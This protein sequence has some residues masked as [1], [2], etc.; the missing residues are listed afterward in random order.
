M[1]SAVTTASNVLMPAPRTSGNAMPLFPS[2]E[3]IARAVVG[4]SRACIWPGVAVVLE[5]QGLPRVDP[6]FGGRYWPAVRDF[7]DRRH[8]VSGVRGD[9]RQA[10]CT[11]S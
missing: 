9:Q 7:L 10:R 6:Q 1:I 5:R 3:E 8:H 11:R 2:E 4:P